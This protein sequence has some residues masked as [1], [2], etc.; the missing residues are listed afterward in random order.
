MPS[1]PTQKDILLAIQAAVESIDSKVD[2]VIAN[3]GADSTN[4]QA[5]ADAQVIHEQLLRSGLDIASLD[6]QGQYGTDGDIIAVDAEVA[7]IPTQVP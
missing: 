5:I 4:I 3:Q 7:T 2:T 6:Y 1:T